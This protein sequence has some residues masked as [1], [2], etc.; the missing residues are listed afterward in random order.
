MTTSYIPTA[1]MALTSLDNEDSVWFTALTQII[2]NC[3][4]NPV[5]IDSAQIVM[6][7]SKY[8]DFINGK[9]TAP[10]S[11]SR[12]PEF[13]I[14]SDIEMEYLPG[15]AAQKNDATEV[16]ETRFSENDMVISYGDIDVDFES[17]PNESL[18]LQKCYEYIDAFIDHEHFQ[19]HGENFLRETISRNFPANNR[20]KSKVE[21]HATLWLTV[22]RIYSDYFTKQLH[23][24]MCVDDVEFEK[25]HVQNLINAKKAVR[26]NDN[27][28]VTFEKLITKRKM[29]FWKSNKL[30]YE[31]EKQISEEAYQFAVQSFE[32]LLEEVLSISTFS[33]HEFQTVYDRMSS[34]VLKLFLQSLEPPQTT[35]WLLKIERLRATLSS[36]QTHYTQRNGI[37][38]S[39]IDQIRKCGIETGRQCYQDEMSNT[40][41]VTK[42]SKD[43]WESISQ[44]CCDA[45]RRA[46]H[47][48]IGKNIS[49]NIAV[50]WE[51]EMNHSIDEMKLVFLAKNDKL[52]EPSKPTIQLQTGI[53]LYIDQQNVIIYF[54]QQIPSETDFFEYDHDIAV[55]DDCILFGNEALAAHNN[56]RGKKC[57]FNTV[58]G[59][60]TDFNDF[61]WTTIVDGRRVKVGKEHILSLYFQR[62]RMEIERIVKQR[63]SSCFVAITGLLTCGAKQILK[64]SLTLAGFEKNTLIPST[65]AMAITYSRK[66]SNEQASERKIHPNLFIYTSSNLIEVA[67]ADVSSD[68]VTVQNICGAYGNS[69]KGNLERNLKNILND[70][71]PVRQCKNVVFWCAGKSQS[72]QNMDSVVKKLVANIFYYS[73]TKIFNT[74]DTIKVTALLDSVHNNNYSM[75]HRIPRYNFI[76]PYRISVRIDGQKSELLLGDFNNHKDIKLPLSDVYIIEFTEQA[77]TSGHRWTVASHHLAYRHKVTNKTTINIL[78]EK[79]GNLFVELNAQ[80]RLEASNMTSMTSIGKQDLFECMKP[81]LERKHSALEPPSSSIP[82]THTSVPPS[83]TIDCASEKQW[84]DLKN[85][86]ALLIEK[87][88]DELKISESTPA[89]HRDNIESKIIK[90]ETLMKSSNIKKK[91]LEIEKRL[92]ERA[93]KFIK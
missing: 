16:N 91:Q 52:P 36:L 45:A 59:L 88:K 57:Y 38:L 67:L 18:M 28:N 14:D 51:T 76:H 17:D 73:D 46:F 3:V 70:H 75:V 80:G 89:A 37:Q 61:V 33:E 82:A 5:G 9:S 41:P 64:T 62:L 43:K 40:L 48:K 60:L 55:Y 4:N 6:W 2:K 71:L 8:V 83:N 92:L 58:F 49:E 27:L 29:F 34:A 50:Q 30:V 42:L 20:L 25:L 93:A 22:L 31:E 47:Q 26:S 24:E 69:L 44:A 21:E 65:T 81:I 78:L 85:S 1:E 86:V 66:L 63:I 53:G 35:P 74:V 7:F 15:C 13:Q 84:E 54:D 23:K 11:V 77:K 19:Q 79:E 39:K 56:I 10:M 32:S 72:H 12:V 90:C 87:T 68:C